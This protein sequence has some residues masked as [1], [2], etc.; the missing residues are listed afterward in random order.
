MATL[1][2][3]T[4]FSPP[5]RVFFSLSK[6]PMY[7]HVPA[8]VRIFE[9]AKDTDTA[10][11]DAF[12]FPFSCTTLFSF[13]RIETRTCPYDGVSKTKLSVAIKVLQ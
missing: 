5:R 6:P 13:R 3:D 1:Y 8:C 12:L 7:D 11:P 4:L 2:E 10:M 9:D